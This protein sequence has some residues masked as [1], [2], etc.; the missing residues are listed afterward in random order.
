MKCHFLVSSAA[1]SPGRSPSWEAFAGVAS[2]LVGTIAA[3]APKRSGESKMSSWW[4]QIFFIFIT[5]WARFPFWLTLFKWVENGWNHQLDVVTGRFTETYWNTQ[6]FRSILGGWKPAAE[7]DSSLHGYGANLKK[8]Q[9]FLSCWCR[10]WLVNMSMCYGKYYPIQSDDFDRHHTFWVLTQVE[11]S[12]SIL[13]GTLLTTARPR[14]S[15]LW[16]VQWSRWGSTPEIPTETL[17]TRPRRSVV[18]VSFN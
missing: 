13:L 10:E 4:F 12:T 16:K 7:S 9:S 15:C 11:E 1:L 2:E 14:R 5:T 3:G 18:T 8:T 17:L 6:F